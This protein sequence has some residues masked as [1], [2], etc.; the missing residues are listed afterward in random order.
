MSYG[1]AVEDIRQQWAKRRITAFAKKHG[2]ETSEAFG[3]DRCCAEISG[4]N[5]CNII[6]V[7]IG[8]AHNL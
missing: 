1:E 5:Q 4:D 3:G 7:A 2:V 6:A 8:G